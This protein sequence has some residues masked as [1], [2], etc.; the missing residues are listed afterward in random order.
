MNPDTP[1]SLDALAGSLKAA[2]VQSGT[3][4]KIEEKKPR[5]AKEETVTVTTPTVTGKDL[6]MPARILFDVLAGMLD[7]DKPAAIQIESFADAL[8]PVLNKYVPVTAAFA[9]EL[10]LAG[11]TAGIGY[12]MF[13]SHQ[14]RVKVRESEQVTLAI[15]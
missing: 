6:Q 7:T 1:P 11:A 8:A 10:A 15:E 12:T 14:Q 13:R 3:D 2:V 9:P 4:A 5:K